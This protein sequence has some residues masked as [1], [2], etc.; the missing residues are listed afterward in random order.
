[1]AL[2]PDPGPAALDLAGL[3]AARLCHDL[4]SPIGAIGN[5]VE[6]MGMAGAGGPEAA[7]VA[8]SAAQASARVRFLRVAFGPAGEGARMGR[9]EVAGLLADVA[10]GGRLSFDWQAGIEAA[11]ADVRRAFLALMCCEHALPAGGQIVIARGEAGW[12]V[13]GSGRRLRI[14]APLWDWLAGRGAA[15]DLGPGQVQFALLRADAAAAGLALRVET[16]EEGVAVG[17]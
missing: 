1:M 14:E 8:D 9:A 16:G 7:L 17:F 15:P 6:L 11:R 4:I 12:R 3:V 10:R 5:G 13:A 2:P